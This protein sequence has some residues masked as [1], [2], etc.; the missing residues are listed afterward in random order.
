[1]RLAEARVLPLEE[2]EWNDAAREIMEP[3]SEGDKQ[4][5]IVKTLIHHPKLMNS[6]GAFGAHVSGDDTSL[7]PRHRELAILRT[8]W[9]CQ[10]EYEWGHHIQVA[11]EISISDEDIERVAAGPD[12][13]GWDPFE[14]TLLRAVDELHADAMITDATWKALAERYDIAQLMDF[15][16]TVGQYTVVSMLLNTLG[17]QPEEGLEGFP[18]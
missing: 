6:L 7:S 10:S 17:V 2:H 8:G 9:L 13:E 11:R 16:A 3:L 1:M 14:A 4:A 5:N 12:A 18:K 15:V